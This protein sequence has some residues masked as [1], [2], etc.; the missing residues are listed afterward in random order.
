MLIARRGVGLGANKE[1]FVERP[2]AC[3]W[4]RTHPG[5]AQNRAVLVL[6]LRGAEGRER[7]PGHQSCG[8]RLRADP[9]SSAGKVHWPKAPC[10]PLLGPLHLP[11]MKREATEGLV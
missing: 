6:W 2:S 8:W 1:P 11:E 7:R 4:A 5:G 9:P 3:L 10:R